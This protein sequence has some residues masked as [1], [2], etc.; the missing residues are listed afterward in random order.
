M[1]PSQPLPNWRLSSRLCKAIFAGIFAGSLFTLAFYPAVAESQTTVADGG[2]H[3]LLSGTALTS[4]TVSSR[5]QV[6]DTTDTIDVQRTPD[7]DIF[8]TVTTYEG[9]LFVT[10]YRR[11]LGSN[12]ASIIRY[13]TVRNEI[14]P[15]AEIVYDGR[16]DFDSGV[17][18]SSAGFFTG[19]P[20]TANPGE[21]DLTYEVTATST[22]CIATFT[23]SWECV[24]NPIVATGQDNERSRNFKLVVLN[25]LP[26]TLRAH[27]GSLT[28]YTFIETETLLKGVNDFLRI[29]VAQENADD[30]NMGDVELE[31]L[32]TTTCKVSAAP[33]AA[34]CPANRVQPGPGRL[35]DTA[36]VP[37]G[38][39]LTGASNPEQARLSG[40]VT[41]AG[42]YTVDYTP[43]Y[44]TFHQGK[45]P[46]K[47]ASANSGAPQ[48]I[49]LNIEENSVPNLQSAI[50]AETFLYKTPYSVYRLPLITGG[51]GELTEV[52]SGTFATSSDAD[53]DVAQISVDSN[54]ELIISLTVGG[55]VATAPT[56][57][58][59][60][61]AGALG[62]SATLSAT[63]SSQF[64]IY[65][66]TYKIS[67][68]DRVVGAAD[69][70]ER[71][72]TL[73]FHE[74]TFVYGNA[75]DPD[76][77]TIVL[78]QNLPLTD[79]L[80]LARIGYPF[81]YLA[82]NETLPFSVQL[83]G[84]TVKTPGS[85]AAD[86][87]LMVNGS[88]TGLKFVPGVEASINIVQGERIYYRYPTAG[89]IEGTPLIA[90]IYSITHR[91]IP[92]QGYPVDFD[93]PLVVVADTPV[94]FKPSDVER[95]KEDIVAVAVPL[96]STNVDEALYR[97]DITQFNDNYLG[98]END[99]GGYGEIS[100]QISTCHYPSKDDFNPSLP[101]S[102][103]N[104]GANA[105][106]VPDAQNPNQQLPRD[107]V[108]ARATDGGKD[109][110][111]VDGGLQHYGYY[112]VLFTATDEAVPTYDRVQPPD[113]ASRDR[114]AAFF[115]LVRNEVP[116]MDSAPL[117]LAYN[118]GSEYDLELPEVSGGNGQVGD[119]LRGQYDPDGAGP[120]ASTALPTLAASGAILL[121]D[122]TTKSGLTFTSLT[123][124]SNGRAS[125]S[126]TPMQAGVFSLIYEAI[127]SDEVGYSDP[128]YPGPCTGIDSGTNY[129]TPHGCDSVQK[130]LNITVQAS[131]APKLV[132]DIASI[133]R[134][135]SGI[136]FAS[137]LT[138]P[139]GS[140]G[141]GDL[142]FTLTATYDGD[143]SAATSIKAQGAAG[144]ILLADDTDTGLSFTPQDGA[145]PGYISGTPE[146]EGTYTLTYTVND[147][148]A[149]VVCTPI[150]PPVNCTTDS[151]SFTLLVLSPIPVLDAKMPALSILLRDTETAIP[152]PKVT[153]GNIS[154]VS[155]DLSGTFTNLDGETTSL[156]LGGDSTSA[157]ISV[158]SDAS[159][160]TLIRH[161]ALV[162]INGR[163]TGTPLPSGTELPLGTL[164]LVYSITDDVRPPGGTL[165]TEVP[166]AL[167]I[168]EPDTLL[169]EQT[170]DGQTFN[171]VAGAAVG[172]SESAPFELALPVPNTGT[173][174]YSTTIATTCTPA[175]GTGS[176]PDGSVI[177][178]TAGAPGSLPLGLTFTAQAPPARSYLSGHLLQKDV[179]YSLTVTVTDSPIDNSFQTIADVADSETDTFNFAVGPNTLPT[180]TEGTPVIDAATFLY[181]EDLPI[182]KLEMPTAGGGDGALTETLSGQYDPD[183]AGG[184]A[185][186]DLVLDANTGAILMPNGTTLSGL[187]FTPRTSSNPAFIEGTPAETGSYVLRYEVNDS[188]GN[189]TACTSTGVPSSCDTAAANFTFDVQE[190]RVP[191]FASAGVQKQIRWLAK[192]RLLSPNLRMPRV[193]SGNGAIKDTLSGNHDPDGDG[194]MLATP[195]QIQSDGKILLSDST[196]TRLRFT[197]LLGDAVG[198]ISGTPTVNGIYSLTYS[199]VDSDLNNLISCAGA[200]PPS[201]C[202][203]AAAVIELRVQV[204]V[205]PT[206]SALDSTSFAG[207]K[208]RELTPAITLPAGGGGNGTLKEDLSGSFASDDSTLDGDINFD[209]NNQIL[210]TDGTESGLTFYPRDSSAANSADN[211]ATISG[212]PRKAGTFTITYSI[213]D[214][215][216]NDTSGDI[217]SVVI[218]LAITQA[219]LELS[220]GIADGAAVDL[221]KDSLLTANIPLPQVTG[222]ASADANLSYSLTAQQTVDS[223]GPIAS[224]EA[225]D[226]IAGDAAAI[227]GL[228]H[229]A[230]SSTL[231][232]T[233]PGFLAGTPDTVGVWL[234]TYSIIDD[235]GTTG[236]GN[237]FDDIS[238][239]IGF[240]LRVIPANTL[241]L[242]PFEQS[243]FQAENAA[244]I[245]DDPVAADAGTPLP[246]PAIS[247]G[248]GA[249]GD[250]IATICTS[251]SSNCGDISGTSGEAGSLPDGLTFTA[252]DL[253][254][255]TAASLTGTFDSA[256]DYS[257]TYSV[258][259]TAISNPYQTGASADSADTVTAAFKLKVQAD[260]PPALDALTDLLYLT[261]ETVDDTLPAARE[262]NGDLTYSLTGLTG[263]GLTFAPLTRKLTGTATTAADYSL[264]YTVADSDSNTAASDTTSVTLPLSV[265][266]DK[267]PTLDAFASNSFTGYA[268]RPLTPVT[269][270]NASGGNGPLTDSLG[271][272][273]DGDGTTFDG[274]IS[275]DDDN[276]II[277]ADG[278]TGSGLTFNPRDGDTDTAASISGKPEHLGTF[279][280]TYSIGDSDSNTADTDRDVAPLTLTITTASLQLSGGIAHEAAVDLA[281]DSLLTGNITLPQVISGASASDNL[282]YSLTAQQT[283]D[284]DGTIDPSMRLAPAT[285]ATATAAIPGLTHTALS[286]SLGT[287]TPGFLAG[288]PDTLGTWLLAYSVIDDNATTGAGNDFDDISASI[289]FSLS[290]VAANT[291][292][293]A[294]S[295]QSDFQDPAA[296]VIVSDPAGAD[297]DTPLP[298]PAISGG[299]GTLTQSLTTSCVLTGTSTPC[300]GAAIDTSG[301]DS[302]PVGLTFAAASG[303]TPASL[304]GA[305]TSAG[306]YSLTY[307]VT[308]TAISNPYQTGASADSAD[309]VTAG[310]ALKVQADSHPTLDA[311]ADL[312]YLTGE[313]L[314]LTLPLA[315]DG[316]GGLTYSLTGLT[317][318]GLTFAPLTRK[319]TGTRSTAADYS[320]TYTATDSDSNIAANDSASVTFALSVQVD[321][322]P[323][324]TSL[325]STSFTGNKDRTLA[326]ISLPV[327]SGGNGSLIESLGGE[328]DGD[329]T[330]LDGD[331]SLDDNNQII[332]A[333]GTTESGLTFT[334]RT[335]GNTPTAASI[336]G[337]PEHLG[338]FTFT[339]SVGDSDSNTADSDRAEAPSMTLTITQADIDLSGGI[340]DGAAVDL[341]KDIRLSN[342]ITLPA[343]SSGASADDNLNYSL[344]AQQTANSAG[345]I[346]PST[347]LDPAT[348]TTAT[349]AIPGL[350]YTAD[351]SSGGTTTAGFLDGTPSANGTWLLVYSIVD[352]NGS[353]DPGDDASDSISFS[354]SVVT[355]NTL[356]LA[357]SSQSDFQDPAATVIVDDPAGADA[358]TPLPMPAISGGYG[359]LTQSLTTSCALTGTSTPCAG[360][361]IDSSGG[362]SAPA[363]LT[364]A[365]ASGSTAASLTGAFTSAGDYS[366]IYSVTDTA[367]S[368]PYQTG[369]SAET[370]TAGFALKVQ[371]DTPPALDAIADLLY[372]TGE[373]VDDTLPAARNGN[374]DL[375]Y[376]LTGLTGSGLTFAPLTR[377]LTGTTTTAADYSLTYT[378]ADSDS[379]TAASDTTVVT[380]PLS[381]QADSAPSLTSLDNNRFTGYAYRPLT[382]VTLP[383]ASGGNGPLI[384]TLAGN[385]A[386]DDS[387]LVGEISLD[388]DNRIIFASNTASGL[389]FNPRD[390]ANAATISGKPEHLGTFT[391]TYSVDD[392]D[393]KIGG[394]DSDS[395]VLFLT[396]TPAVLQLGNGIADEAAVDLA[397]DS[398]LT[399]NITLP[400]VIDGAS[401]AANLSYS[402]TAQQ[403]ADS[404]GTIA[405]PEAPALVTTSSVAI[406][407]LSYTPLSTS[408]GTTTPG[409]LA[410]TP[411]TL[412]IWQF[413]YSVI[414]DNGTT[415]AGNDFDDVSAGISFSLH[416]LDNDGPSLQT[417][418]SYNFNYIVAD[419]VG[420]D[421]DT[422]FTLPAISG[423]HGAVSD[424]ISTSCAPT[425]GSGT[426]AA[427][428]T[429]GTAGQPGSL[430]AGLTFTAAV[431]A[432]GASA[433]TAASL[434]G[435]F[436][437]Y[438]VTYTFSY[439]ATDTPLTL[440]YQATDTANTTTADFTFVV[441]QGNNTPTFS[442]QTPA[443]PK[444]LEKLPADNADNTPNT[445]DDARLLATLTFADAD[446]ADTLSYSIA[447]VTPST[448]STSDFTATAKTG[449]PLQAEL[450]FIGDASAIDHDDVQSFTV[451]VS[452][453]DSG[454]GGKIDQPVEVTVLDNTA[455]TVSVAATGTPSLLPGSTLTLTASASDANTGDGDILSYAWT[456][457]AATAVAGATAAIGD[458]SL[459]P[460]NDQTGVSLNVP[461]NFFGTTYT[462]QVAVTDRAPQTTT[463]TYSLVVADAPI[464]F[465]YNPSPSG[466]PPTYS[467]ANGI[468]A[469][470]GDDTD[471]IATIT[472]SDPN[473]PS[474]DTLQYSGT[475]S[476]SGTD[477]VLGLSSRNS[478][479]ISTIFGFAASGAD[480]GELSV[481]SSTPLTDILTYQ[482]RLTV[483]K[484]KGDGSTE[485]ATADFDVQ[486]VAPNAAMLIADIDD[487]DDSPGG[488]P[489]LPRSIVGTPSTRAI[490]L[491][492]HF[493]PAAGLTFEA[494]SDNT[495]VLTLS[496]SGGVLT[497]TATRAGGFSNVKVTASNTST[498]LADRPSTTF[499]VAVTPTNDPILPAAEVTNIEVWS[500]G[501]TVGQ[502]VTLAMDDYFSDPDTPRY[503]DTLSYELLDAD[504][505]PQSSIKH[506]QIKGGSATDVLTVSLTTG[507]LTLAP[508][509]KT[510]ADL[511]VRVRATDNGGN[512][513]IGTFVT[514]VTNT[515]PTGTMTIDPQIAVI[516]ETTTLSALT[517]TDYFSDAETLPANLTFSASSNKPAA[518]SAATVDATSKILSLTVP[519]SA[520]PADTAT[521][522]ITATDE[523]STT[524]VR[525]FA[526]TVVSRPAFGAATYSADLNENTSGSGTAVLLTDLTVNGGTGAKTYTLV[527]V[528]GQT[529]GADYGKF[530]VAAKLDASN[531]PIDT[532]AAVTYSG[533]SEDYEARKALSTPNEPTFVLVIGVSDS[534]DLAALVNTTLTVTLTDVNEA[535]TAS[536]AC[537]SCTAP[538]TAVQL[539]A[540]ASDP[541]GDS[542]TYSW[543]LTAASGTGAAVGDIDLDTAT[544]GV[545]DSVSAQ[546]PSI[547]LPNKRAGSTYS[548][549]LQVSDAGTPALTASATLAL[550]L[551]EA[552]ARFVR[553]N[554]DSTRTVLGSSLALSAPFGSGTGH[555]LAT[556]Q[557]EDPNGGPLTYSLSGTHASS[558]AFEDDPD[559][560]NYGQLTLV[561]SAGLSEGDYSLTLTAGKTQA[562]GTADST[563]LSVT[564][565]VQPPA[566]VA[567]SSPIPDQTITRV[568]GSAAALTLSNLGQHFTPS[569]DLI[570]TTP[571]SSNPAVATVAIVDGDDLRLTPTGAGGTTTI[572]YGASNVPRPTPQTDTF[573]L[574][575]TPSNAPVFTAGNIATLAAIDLKPSGVA[576]KLGDYFSDPDSAVH[577]D[578]LTYE[579]LD[580]GG[581][582]RSS[583][584]Y[585]QTIGGTAT[586]VLTVTLSG[587]DLTL[588][589]EGV[590]TIAD[591]PLTLRATDNGGNSQNGTFNASVSNAAPTA[592]GSIGAITLMRGNSHSLSNLAQYFADDQGTDDLT[593]SYTPDSGGV[594]TGTLSS[595][596]LS[597]QAAS[598]AP[599]ATITATLTA[600]DSASQSV[601][602]TITV[603]V[604][605]PA[606]TFGTASVADTTYIQGLAAGVSGNAAALS[607]P[608]VSTGT[609]APPLA[610]SL[611][612]S[613]LSGADL[614]SSQVG[615]NTQQ[616][617]PGMTLSLSAP[618]D[619][620]A[621]GAAT[622]SGTPTQIGTYSMVWSVLDGNGAS[623]S[624]SA[625]FQI[626]VVADTQPSLPSGLTSLA[627]VYQQDTDYSPGTGC[628]SDPVLSRNLRQSA[629][630]RA[631]PQASGGN[632]ALTY[633]LTPVP[634][635]MTFD[636]SARTL[637]GTPNTP[638]VY[639]AQYSVRDGDGD[640]AILPLTLTI[641][642]T[643]TL[644][645][646]EDLVLDR[647]VPLT[648]ATAVNLPRAT[649]GNGSPTYSLIPVIGDD[650]PA[651]LSFDPS[652]LDL[653]G[654]PTYS[655]DYA[656]VYRATDTD[657]DTADARFRI[658]VDGTPE[659]AADTPTLYDLSDDQRQI[660]PAVIEGSGNGSIRYS[661]EPAKGSDLQASDYRFIPATRAL[662]L[663]TPSL[664]S[665]L[666]ISYTATDADGDISEPL[667]LELNNSR[668]PIA[669][670]GDPLNALPGQQVTLDGSASL[671]PNGEQLAYRW[672]QQSGTAVTLSGANTP[673]PSFT[674]PQTA[675]DLVFALV[676]DDGTLYST[677]DTARVRVLPL[678]GEVLGRYM[679]A[680]V[681]TINNVLGERTT[682]LASGTQAQT[683]V[684]LSNNS[685]GDVR[686][687]RF[688]LPLA[689][690]GGSADNASSARGSINAYKK[691]AAAW[692]AVRHDTLNEKGGRIDSLSGSDTNL[693]V[694]VDLPLAGNILGGILVTRSQGDL[695][696]DLSFD[697]ESFSNDYH[698]NLSQFTPYLAFSTP[699]LNLWGG[700]GFGNL[701]IES[702]IGSVRRFEASTTTTMANLRARIIDSA[703]Q[704]HLRLTSTSATLSIARSQLGQLA[705]GTG[706]AQG[707]YT[708]EAA[709]TRLGLELSS[710]VTLA[711]GDRLV[712]SLQLAS[713]D[714]T[715]SAPLAGDLD[716]GGSEVGFGLRYVLPVPSWAIAVG[717]R[718][719]TMGDGREED[720]VYVLLQLDPRNEN[721]GLALSLKPVWGQMDSTLE[722]LWQGIP[723]NASGLS[724]SG[725]SNS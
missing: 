599:P 553:I 256:G 165:V 655:D 255:G 397:K 444:L 418:N 632:G 446:A 529:S 424:S 560:A 598:N 355:A 589:P 442:G 91:L 390:G 237:D 641:D 652:T 86:G 464:V 118:Q 591:I 500:K 661:V 61:P 153:S 116:S 286:S 463:A 643:P 291:L 343:V 454:V 351:S 78:L 263:S 159:G 30:D 46:A 487:M 135:A 673:T 325:D 680:Q 410:G 224:P 217:A 212:T 703:T 566:P 378:V 300:A 675:N 176:C 634:A 555:L 311:I 699:G 677:P 162:D 175:S 422:P 722:Q 202:D 372:L 150:N 717:G 484:T 106:Y 335:G 83:P 169:I 683:D 688:V 293:L 18:Y 650:L 394:G 334:P 494:T 588:T 631:L 149:I 241:S 403:T 115:N 64:G 689:R 506:Q 196:D 96:L 586:D 486:V 554:S 191:T 670:A 200:S 499:K 321:S 112:R 365:P 621:T 371:A 369:D 404:D 38:V 229:T 158:G 95:L 143:A 392:S 505:T 664:S 716:T 465:S 348:I 290:V 190:H 107:T 304:T 27:D 108:V 324:L 332:F 610:Y 12:S 184:T 561:S 671:D 42:Y 627:C 19:T 609:G 223:D 385:F 623:A 164:S 60:T 308:D 192:D 639:Q 402:L 342:N 713:V 559:N 466:T 461:A 492:D 511:S 144:S 451:T 690:F 173:P 537:A 89:Y 129:P 520:S 700:A 33:T 458:I 85:M 344:T 496:E 544:A 533:T 21:Y 389:T 8:R 63:S 7:G 456:V 24:G 538:G 340:A 574:S 510:I 489:S 250:R 594:L 41:Y 472:A 69:E 146:V 252:A 513:H 576:L 567:L 270:P 518:V 16:F 357:A 302:A 319:L 455:P 438:G 117:S 440:T 614:G 459:T 412:G 214:S 244:V 14:A 44:A 180:L 72:F 377:K 58:I 251:A 364:F 295:S 329:G 130:P 417:F 34:Q 447:G 568:A 362:N 507:T 482:L 692:G 633:S 480:L 317:G 156:T 386:G 284:S 194:P 279:T 665:K 243:D 434:S 249:I 219:V 666:K 662:S 611:S 6:P 51:D 367:I 111:F 595:A 26:V 473:D 374:G 225:P 718:V 545:Q 37:A 481:I 148:R 445:H 120:A 47:I 179:L 653:T 711:N 36:T 479:D 277:F 383:T 531:N 584:T 539:R 76:G 612:G 512:L 258:T 585:R 593:Y 50:P 264:T 134:V 573:I 287:T 663:N 102:N 435:A 638:T 448:L 396:I 246:M 375:T 170:L 596:G 384:D 657:G 704:L 227:P 563:S 649:G 420:A 157:P 679:L 70:Y 220:G 475:V 578:I 579:L 204:D 315:R 201:N 532:T 569:I 382:P 205:S 684:S 155:Y 645:S 218:T 266:T 368:N 75:P 550:T 283:A 43:A 441:A 358:D 470:S 693:H 172:A 429:S 174:P 260:V 185:A 133:F 651:G 436:T 354:L 11:Y 523:S 516:G 498:Q 82:P 280:L 183:G 361:A 326:P 5:L 124:S 582:P 210:L 373:T 35:A 602:Q 723:L 712:P 407:G 707:D 706:E 139:L 572:T 552:D 515:V 565:T 705:S 428:D 327:A 307:S 708:V 646:L 557:A 77:D 3:Y 347:R 211:V 49:K 65:K 467:V 259:D 502:N 682:Q 642:G 678:Y 527:S 379:N 468:V 419:P 536:A 622:L 644:A 167:K 698:L 248:Y 93:I 491:Y 309:T 318:S 625:S 132:G 316:N 281:K 478:T 421:A 345:T 161:R 53:A 427:A 411:D 273:F 517:L 233:T 57:V 188:D 432:A 681:D 549:S 306:D 433:G 59:F 31:H 100:Y 710:S 336:G 469:T 74:P 29:I 558:F 136:P 686:L 221:I 668:A 508:L 676:V 79:D 521:I 400:Q 110:L 10:G 48:Q 333:D 276:Q 62:Q 254:A 548:F 278:T 303:S 477:T 415:G 289:S 488:R 426:C 271:G 541:D 268:Y 301:G 140:G 509:A 620:S 189:T 314:D 619:T 524:A 393:S 391:L 685:D 387:R 292:A 127:D 181:E 615:G 152:L 626:T 131:T 580:S 81:D 294:A 401:A 647:N 299:Y 182:P 720:G 540:T 257:L 617:P 406:A 109:Y 1:P 564:A 571:T 416:V 431:A 359:A 265:Q 522:T 519:A 624:L 535:P 476:V 331:I 104:S 98:V 330:T 234:L 376:S 322:A 216:N 485:A 22:G 674:A 138:L 238:A 274:S 320:L 687:N 187:S 90:G 285:I 92:V 719:R 630:S 474:G 195:I 453:D 350:T 94:K 52:L 160:L 495:K 230:L 437:S 236:T 337:R 724:N 222:G 490:N 562:D 501:M 45:V 269:L 298:M 178:A 360:A 166:F 113:T 323:S 534:N 338:T 73:S 575:V 228:T 381:V 247:G 696:F 528:N 54:G 590:P 413:A 546:N 570:F 637:S 530:A 272:S 168:V 430:P 504:G 352:D 114:V 388:D 275:F 56:G 715:M 714:E 659:F 282:S 370:V 87:T 423:G 121:P 213:G 245:V 605:N 695:D 395:A 366:L 493:S 551:A 543:T 462:I 23:L 123:N 353:P 618:G 17:T 20:N 425:S 592:V 154:S 97:Y 607:L 125:I 28:P 349:A 483:A 4:G 313:A 15:G 701:Y 460:T 640:T 197:H 126:G 40:G 635:G 398:P 206:L 66:L 32:L 198:F 55:S 636:A 526:V 119:L 525:I 603:H 9:R 253:D 405:S 709:R 25:N 697:Q 13:G 71:A 380:L 105:V 122:G 628:P 669:D 267:A 514:T 339:Y 497:L 231:G 409:T 99:V 240:S 471:L 583:I 503:G 103:C 88:S 163:I 312:L 207:K 601:A 142:G 261:G 356:S 363:G 137:Q 667:I 629:Y 597:L 297:A 702:G 399:S 203:T 296:V 672:T 658:K 310:F 346:D 80:T 171:Y 232:T 305:F 613:K 288:T 68:G 547:T 414:D 452:A 101:N 660:L 262:G 199:L 328:F 581:T 656:M 542:L 457:T 67:D 147:A 39:T 556:I 694:G 145:T 193:T 604:A 239:S 186:A 408:S 721:R 177:G 577:G 439:S 608:R 587:S 691:V 450:R 209:A 151:V 2:T 128:S 606:P 443:S 600:S 141:E 208:D 449:N 654:T 616:H 84:S 235:N 242:A 341:I 725:L 648:G 215:D 226:T